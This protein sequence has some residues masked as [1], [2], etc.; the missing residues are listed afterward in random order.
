MGRM[1]DTVTVTG[2]GTARATP[3]VAVL[4]LS[5]EVRAAI[6]AEAYEGAAATAKKVVDAALEAGIPRSDL[7]TSGLYVRPEMDWQYRS[8][9]IVGYFAGEGFTVKSRDLGRTPELLDAVVRAAGDALR[10][11]GLALEV[12]DPAAAL[13]AAQEAAFDDARAAAERLARRA[14]RS[15]GPAIR[16]DVAGPLAPGMPVPFVRAAAVAS[17]A[18]QMPIEAGEAELRATVTVAWRLAEPDDASLT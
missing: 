10:I 14:G 4:R 6:L 2:T 15:L 5:V 11:H 3:D 17:S 13:A 16:I 9:K 12:D 7:A 8:G 18:E 1:H